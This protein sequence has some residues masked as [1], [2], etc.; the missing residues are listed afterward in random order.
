MDMVSKLVFHL[1]NGR[2]SVSVL[3]GGSASDT[4]GPQH[5]VQA[6]GAADPNNVV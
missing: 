2:M 3:V 1:K 4:E 6:W 5:L